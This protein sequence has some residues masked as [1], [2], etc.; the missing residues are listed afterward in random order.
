MFLIPCDIHY[1]GN[2]PMQE[3]GHMEYPVQ[4]VQ[5]ARDTLL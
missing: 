5:W 3:Y 1:P 4:F 2:K